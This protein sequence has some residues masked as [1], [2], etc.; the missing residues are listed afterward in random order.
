MW[1]A[2]YVKSR[3][4]EMVALLVEKCIE[5][6]VPLRKVLKQWSTCNIMLYIYKNRKFN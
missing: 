2:I 4:E 1:L 6:Y 5:A 3:H